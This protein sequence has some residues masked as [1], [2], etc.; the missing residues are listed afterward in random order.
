MYHKMSLNNPYYEFVFLA[1]IFCCCCL[2]DCFLDKGLPAREYSGKLMNS[3]NLLIQQI[4]NTSF[5]IHS[6]LGPGKYKYKIQAIPL[7]KY[8]LINNVVK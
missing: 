2:F 1:L 4:F 6:V 3:T 8:G 5:I 7:K